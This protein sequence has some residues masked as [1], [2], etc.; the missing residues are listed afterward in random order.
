MQVPSRLFNSRA[1]WMRL[2]IDISSTAMHY[3]KDQSATVKPDPITL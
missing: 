3:A 1:D 2:Q